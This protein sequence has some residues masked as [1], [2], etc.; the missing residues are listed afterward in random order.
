M[1]VRDDGQGLAQEH[2]SGVG[3]QA[4]QERAAELNGQCMIQSLPGG[5]TL[6]KAIL[7]LEVLDE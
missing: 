6:V 4:M 5:G 1:E 2:R 3:L 7:P